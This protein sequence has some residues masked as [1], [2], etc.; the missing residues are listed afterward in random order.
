MVDVAVNIY[1]QRDNPSCKAP[2]TECQLRWRSGITI[3]NCYIL[4]GWTHLAGWGRKKLI[5]SR[6][7]VFLDHIRKL[8]RRHIL[9]MYD[10]RVR[11]PCDIKVFSNF[12][13][14][15]L[16]SQKG[17]I[18]YF[19]RYK[20][21]SKAPSTVRK[22]WRLSGISF[23]NCFIAARVRPLKSILYGIKTHNRSPLTYVLKH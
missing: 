8:I 4:Y 20:Q 1:H 7:L 12:S 14:I 23:S 17:L 13:L 19:L 6:I 22:H 5:K 2:S 3:G 10:T 11:S 18:Y 16:G 9:L 21:F 15:S